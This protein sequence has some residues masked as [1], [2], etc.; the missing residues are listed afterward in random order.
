MK[1][2]TSKTVEEAVQA[3]SKAV[4]IPAEQLIYKV[5]EEKKG[6]FGIGKEATI[7][8]YDIDDAAAF[9]EEYLKTALGG[10]GVE[11]ETS[12]T[13]DEDI[14][15][16]NI[17][18]ERNPI[19]IGKGGRT[20]QALNELARL[21]VSNKFRHRYRILLDVGGYKEDKYDRL[22]WVAKKTAREVIKTKVSVKL[23]PMTADERRIIHNTLN[24]MSHIKTE[25]SGEGHD[26]AVTIKYVD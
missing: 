18:S 19:L 16:V 8:I 25:S 14:I 23:D 5:I 7:E 9:A 11:A 2:F 15:H 6:L 20:L 13:I 22:Q 21:A 26:R 24:G 4:N 17:N 12:S 10:M 3:A 1:H